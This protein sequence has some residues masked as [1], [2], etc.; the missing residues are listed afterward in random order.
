[1]NS[2]R[3]P[4]REWREILSQIK[5]GSTQCGGNFTNLPAIQQA[6]PKLEFPCE[7]KNV[8][9]FEVTWDVATRPHETPQEQPWCVLGQFKLFGSP[10]APAEKKV[11]F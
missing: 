7:V 1:M 6:G 10:A 5:A 11:S 8:K 4:W 3:Q 2:P 9:K